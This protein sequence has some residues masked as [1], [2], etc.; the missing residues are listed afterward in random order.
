MPSVR[1]AYASR[2]Q[3][4]KIAGDVDQIEL[5]AVRGHSAVVD[6]ATR[7]EIVSGELD[8]DAELR[9]EDLGT[10]SWQQRDLAQEE[11]VGSAADEIRARLVELGPAYP[12]EFT[13]KRLIH[14]P[15]RSG[16]YEFCLAASTAPSITADPYTAFPRYF[17]R[18][19]AGLIR[20]YFG[21]DKR[22]LHVGWP[23]RPSTSF[24]VAM[25]P[26]ARQRFE[27]VWGPEDG[28][29]DDPP[30]TVT[31][32][33]SV[34]FVVTI[35]LLDSRPGNLYVLGQCACGNDWDTKLGEPDAKRIAKWFRPAWIIDPLRAF[36][37]PFV[38]GDQTIRETSRKSQ[39]IVFD[40]IRLVLVAENM[41]PVGHQHALRRRLAGVSALVL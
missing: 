5:A 38:L 6:E 4:P 37:T 29:D 25:S 12:F 26:L 13:G 39:A 17:E 9:A 15:S 36:T 27:W 21:R 23:R 19:V 16:F 18:A 24:K 14:R 31:K 35:D 11:I 34:D 7:D 22:A 2:T 20:Y 40:R 10:E 30:H 32:D 28:M 33:E 1:S 41:I 3:E 8:D